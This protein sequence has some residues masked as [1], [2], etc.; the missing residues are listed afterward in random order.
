MPNTGKSTFFNRLTGSNAHVA[1]WPGITVDLQVAKIP[2]DGGMAEFVD[3]P[4]IYSLHGSSDD[5]RVVCR[6]L[7]REPVN[8]CVLLLHAAQLDRQLTLALQLKALKLPMVMLL[9][10]A[11]EA[12]KLG[13]KVD[14]EKL[15]KALGFPVHLLS[16]KYGRGFAEV[17]ESIESLVEQ[18]PVAKL[19]EVAI[20]N[21]GK[22]QCLGCSA[23]A[24]ASGNGHAG[25]LDAQLDSIFAGAVNLPDAL[26]EQLSARLDRVLLHPWFGL[27]LFFTTIF[28]LFELVYRI[29]LPLQD[30]M[31]EALDG[32]QARFLAPALS[33]A[34]V[35]LKSFL[36]DGLYNGIGTVASFLPVIVIF[37]V[38]MAVV[39]DSGYLARAA[40]LMDALMAKLGLDGR[41][42][43]IQ[44]MGY[45]CNVPAI[46][47]TRVMRS[48]P[49]RLLTMLIVPFSLC[50]ARLQVFVFLI[51]A[52][53]AASV[54]PVVLFSLYLASFAVAI[55]TA[56]VWAPRYRSDEPM[57]LELP[58]YRLPTPQHLFRQAWQVA[59][60][61][62]SRASG[63]IVAGVVIIWFLTHFP[64]GVP[65]ASPET[66]AGRLADLLS[67]VFKPVGISP[68]LSLTLMVGFVAKEIVIGA[69]AVI[70]ASGQ[71]HLAGVMAKNLTWPEAY[72]FMLFTLIYT[73]C[74]STIAAIRQESASWRFTVFSIV[75]S[76]GLAWVVSLVFYQA[77]RFLA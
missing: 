34:P 27:P 3:L 49:M 47:G 26:P 10:M 59:Q 36:L 43:V 1:N 63:F 18:N 16:A 40:F 29:G 62:L 30:W 77:V 37:F 66:L 7:E 72:S 32:V 61:F 46:L 6:F 50:S 76:L 42:F 71:A 31:T 14:T 11:D 70:Y 69:L 4:G 55:L 24:A 58:P 12:E 44:L 48:R 60:R 15:S 23:C 54:A 5:E 33:S 8:L 38:V 68:L 73:P 74:L 13:V 51:G 22:G 35:L 64:T 19:A 52:I 67:P 65:A 56:L 41:A 2:L 9:N 53:F 21:G 20:H 25:D 17:R 57:L 39:E 45:G 28:L 75:W